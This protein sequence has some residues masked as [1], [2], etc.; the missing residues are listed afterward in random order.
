M[1]AC[2]LDVE[3]VPQGTLAER[4]RAAGAGLG[5]ILTQLVLEL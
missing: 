3:L 5:G 1:N 2:E 4:I